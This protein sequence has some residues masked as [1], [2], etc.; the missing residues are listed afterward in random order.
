M[1]YLNNG[2][3]RFTVTG[4]W[5]VPDVVDTKSA[6]ADVNGDGKIDVIAANGRGEL[7]VPQSRGRALRR[8]VHSHSG[9]IAT[10]I[11]PA[12]FDKDGFVDLAVPSRDG[13][14]SHIYFQ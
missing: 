14:Q 9:G 4:T 1:V 13:G 2:K 8:G 5:G 11:V 10:S 3:G 6:V 12:D 7:R